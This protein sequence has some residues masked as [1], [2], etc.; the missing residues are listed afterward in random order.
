MSKTIFIVRG[1]PGSGKSTIGGK[2]GAVRSADDYFTS[3]RGEYIFDPSKIVAA[4]AACQQA[5]KTDLDNGDI[6]VVA[7][8]FCMGWEFTP[9]IEIAAEVSA[10]VVV[11]D[12]FDG[13]LDDAGL[14]A[15]NVHGVS[16]AGIAAMRARWEADWRA[17]DPRP[18]WERG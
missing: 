9:Y 6:A 17:A 14:E 10:A 13:G 8:T 2:F 5:V 16:A 12:L 1:L 18:P 3:D 4:H 15:R 11:V 7:N